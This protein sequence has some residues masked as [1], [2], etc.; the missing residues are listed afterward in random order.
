MCTTWHG[1]LQTL[2]RHCCYVIT[3]VASLFL[4]HMTLLLW[5]CQVGDTSCYL[6]LKFTLFLI[7]IE[8]W[9]SELGLSSNMCC[10][11]SKERQPLER[12]PDYVKDILTILHGVGMRWEFTV[13]SDLL[14]SNAVWESWTCWQAQPHAF[15]C[16]T[17]R[18]VIYGVVS[19]KNVLLHCRWIAMNLF[20]L[21]L[22]QLS[23]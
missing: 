19:I 17:D 5:H 11:Q 22:S 6:R 13:Y 3:V 1:G 20:A 18:D 23:A 2:T 21:P 7:W 14:D 10:V 16:E 12:C 15:C 4:G 9:S 8:Y